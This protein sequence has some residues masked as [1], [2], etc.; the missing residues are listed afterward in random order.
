MTVYLVGAGPGDPELLTMRAVNLLRRADVVV[1][2]RLVE[3]A[4]L[5]LAPPWAE[6]VNAG[7]AP[8]YRGVSQEQIHEILLDR[9]QCFECVVRL[10]GGDPFVFGRGGEEAEALRKAGLEIEVVPGVTSAVAAPAAAGI[11]VTLRGESSG[12]TVVTA[13]RDPATD[14][15]LDWD[16]LARSGT[17]LVIL[18]GAAQAA[19]ISDRLRSA[20]M[21]PCTPTTVVRAATT[22]RQHVDR[23]TLEGLGRLKVTSPSVIVIGAV[24]AHDVITGHICNALTSPNTGDATPNTGDA[25]PNTNTHTPNTNTHT[26]NTNTHTPNTDDATPNTNTHTL[27]AAA[28]RYSFVSHRG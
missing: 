23:T 22:K 16:C 18:M 26:P 19:R 14:T 15:T 7:K 5:D 13:H 9:S 8:G 17:T 25:T 21:P 6:R 11:P 20:G 1:H 27:D 4:V 24:A 28:L 2:D 10:K 3:D 12:F